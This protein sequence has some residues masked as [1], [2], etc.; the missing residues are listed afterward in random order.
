MVFMRRPRLPSLAL[1]SASR[2]SDAGKGATS[3]TAQKWMK[4]FLGVVYVH[5]V[6]ELSPHQRYCAA[7]GGRLQSLYQ[8]SG[9]SFA[10]STVDLGR[11]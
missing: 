10:I 7:W 9:A 4:S 1:H 8:V 11:G 2:C 5:W 6:W 3:C